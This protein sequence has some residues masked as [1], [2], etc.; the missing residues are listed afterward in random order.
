MTG[1]AGEGDGGGDDERDA[2]RREV[3]K[4]RRVNEVLV[5]RVEQ[6]MDSHGGAFA[7]F[8]AAIALERQVQARTQEL[9]QALEQLRET[10][11]ALEQAKELADAGSRAKSAFL[12][13]MSHEIRTPLNG[14]I[15]LAELLGATQLSAEQQDLTQGI[16]RSADMLL[17]LL[18]D[19]L[20]LSKIEA[21]RMQLDPVACDLRQLLDSVREVFGGVCQQKGLQL[22]IAVAP[23]VPAA[24]VVDVTRLRQVLV[25]LVGNAVKFTAS[26]E[27]A[28][29]VAPAGAGAIGFVVSDT[30]IGIGAEQR[31]RLFE[32]FVQAEV[33]MARRFGGTGLGLAISRHL[34]RLMGG[35]LTVESELGR[36]ASFR[37]EVP[38]VAVAAPAS[39]PAPRKELPRVDAN[40]LVV[41]DNA[42]NRTVAARMLAKLGCAVVLA[43]DGA[44]AV[45]KA[46]G[47]AFDLVLMD[48]Q[49]PGMDGLEATR[50][51]RVGAVTDA[52][53]LALT[54][55]ALCGD[56]ERCLAAG[57][58]AYLE[59]PLRIHELAAAVCQW[60]PDRV[61]AAGG[62]A[63]DAARGAARAPR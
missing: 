59:K 26:G 53:I 35:D 1:V 17:A 58:N 54:A 20:D 63:A 55:N 14:V 25:N 45:A 33:S 60:L 51:M 19:V 23:A 39:A 9:A 48:V 36:G 41:D 43:E 16:E 46:A 8:E 6:S 56:E 10:N 62:A 21:G 38:A 47:A 52:P 61:R 37:F 2:L 57:M 30:G 27:V 32:P 5:R 31:A 7:M 18:N 13:M 50:R 34:C 12:A 49:M 11:R 22:R 40:V 29:Q 24:I 28:V 4:L 15:G 44:D 42:V 3:A